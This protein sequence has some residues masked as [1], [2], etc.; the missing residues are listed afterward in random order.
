M[1][2]VIVPLVV[3]VRVV[4]PCPQAPSQLQLAVKCGLETRLLLIA[5]EREDGSGH[6][7]D[8]GAAND[9]ERAGRVCVCTPSSRARSR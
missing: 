9:F 8:V 1:V 4:G 6:D 5:D 3:G 7:G 2:G